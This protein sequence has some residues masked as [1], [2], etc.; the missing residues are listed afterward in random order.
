[1]EQSTL[2][3]LGAP[4]TKG[5]QVLIFVTVHHQFD[6]NFI[7]CG[8]TY[9][10]PAGAFIWQAHGNDAISRASVSDLEMYR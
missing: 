5:K 9:H 1:M 4:G 7:Y 2:N 8:T 6:L 10:N 3:S